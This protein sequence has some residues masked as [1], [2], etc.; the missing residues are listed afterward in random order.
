[1]TSKNPPAT[2]RPLDL[3]V[4]VRYKQAIA[5]G[6]PRN[7]GPD[8]PAFRGPPVKGFR[9]AK[10]DYTPHQQAIISQYYNQLDTIM[11]TK[12]QEL[13]TELY[14]ADTDA[15]KKKLWERVEKAMMKLEVPATILEHILA[16]RDVQILAKNVQ[17]WFVKSSRKK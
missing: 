2:F 1:M 6:D 8:D 15:K 9:M 11:L 12:L 5:V 14:L 10:Q 4:P 3:F 13:V 17:E 16:K 7:D